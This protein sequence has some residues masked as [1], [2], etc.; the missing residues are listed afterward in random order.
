MGK[1][2]SESQGKKILAKQ[3]LVNCQLKQSCDVGDNKI[4]F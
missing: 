2:K 3:M 4:G 1:D